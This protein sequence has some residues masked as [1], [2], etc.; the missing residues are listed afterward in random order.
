MAEWFPGFETK[1]I[2]T[3]EAEIHLRVGGSGPAVLMLHG[4]PQC[5][6][7]WR[8]MAPKLSAEYTVVCPDTRGYGESSV[9]PTDAEHAPYS[10]RA[11]ARDMAAVMTELGHT[12]FAVVGH[13]RGA[14]VGYRLALDFSDRVTR[15]CSLDVIPTGSVWNKANKNWSLSSFHW[16]FLAQPAPKPESLISKDPDHWFMWLLESWA[17][18]LARYEADVLEAYK[19]FHRR[20]ET[21]QAMCEDYRA[22]ATVDDALDQADLAAG[23]K[24]ACPVLALWGASR[25]LGGPAG[26]ALDVWRQWADE[27]SG[28]PID[29]GHFLPEEAPEKVLDQ[30]VPFL[31]G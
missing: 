6:L 11:M 31:A 12:T 14:R 26:E 30:L 5:H 1:R 4:Y 25:K 21:L 2:D 17:D 19:R 9:P 28:G 16:Q 13:D 23:N 3:G 8:H 29:C 24:L 18:S 7:L 10:K 15:F 22:G 27:V 20:P